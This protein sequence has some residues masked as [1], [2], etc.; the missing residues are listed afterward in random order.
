MVSFTAHRRFAA[1][2]E[3]ASAPTLQ[4]SLEIGSYPGG[5][6][7]PARLDAV[8]CGRT[9]VGSPARSMRAGPSPVP[10]S[11]A[12]WRLAAGH[13]QAVLSRDLPGSL[14]EIGK[15]LPDEGTNGAADSDPGEPLGLPRPVAMRVCKSG[16]GHR[17]RGPAARDRSG[18]IPGRAIRRI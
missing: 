7:H 10:R 16:G 5:M 14:I 15:G 12:A 18:A 8:V 17:R 1:E 9:A 3:G 4:R 6:G 11:W 2:K 13:E